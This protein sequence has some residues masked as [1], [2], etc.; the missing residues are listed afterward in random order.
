MLAANGLVVWNAKNNFGIRVTVATLNPFREILGV[1]KIRDVAFTKAF[2]S[3]DL[4]GNVLSALHGY[5]W[6]PHIF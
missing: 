4:P 2:I 1:G 6:Q 5:K 3:D